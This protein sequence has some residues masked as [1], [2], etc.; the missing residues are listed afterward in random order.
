MTDGQEYVRT[1]GRTNPQRL[2]LALSAK[3]KQLLPRGLWAEGFGIEGLAG[4]LRGAQVDTVTSACMARYG[5]V[6]AQPKAQL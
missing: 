6:V 1:S 5:N 3:E 4:M 2:Q